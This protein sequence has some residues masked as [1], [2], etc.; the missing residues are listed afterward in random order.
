MGSLL[1]IQ[2]FIIETAILHQ[3]PIQDLKHINSFMKSTIGI[4]FFIININNKLT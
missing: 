3:K 2:K 4:L 1:D